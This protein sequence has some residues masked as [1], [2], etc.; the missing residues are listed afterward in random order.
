MQPY[1]QGN[2]IHKVTNL[3]KSEKIPM[4]SLNLDLS[5]KGSCLG[6]SCVHSNSSSSL[7]SLPELQLNCSEKFRYDQ[8]NHTDL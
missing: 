7:V 5:A 6:Q 1:S 3:L 2:L 4:Q 8:D